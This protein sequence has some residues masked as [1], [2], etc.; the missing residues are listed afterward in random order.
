MSFTEQP[1]SRIIGV[2]HYQPEKVLTNFDLEK[3]VET[4]DE[5]IQ[6]RT[7]IIERRIA[8]DDEEL[9]AMSVA[10]ARMAIEHAGIDV[11]DIDMVVLATLSAEDRSPNIAG[12]VSAALGC[13]APAVMDINVACSGFAHALALADMAIATGSARTA[14][15]IGME[16]LSAFTDWSDRSTCV[17][18]ADGGGAA[19]L[20]TAESGGVSPVTWGSAPELAGAVRV[21]RPS[22]SFSQDGRQILRWSMVEAKR[23]AQRIVERA[24][25]TMEDI[26]VFI[27]HQA[28]LRMI[29]PL[30][31]GLGLREDA[32]VA[33]DVQWS[34]NTSAGTIPLA[35]SKLVH[36]GKAQSG[37]TAL[38][39]GFGGGFAWAGQVVTLP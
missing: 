14:L 20:T 13:T 27:P 24:G 5:W 12:R 25:L 3:M 35:M 33:D 39:F 26:D 4:S 38:L 11:V 32:V 18:V 31:T 17:L 30:A 8:A 10:A 2:G 19:V 1:G 29:E 36:D 15:V 9:D 23:I 21:E 37:A 7:G 34:G 28:N 16:K 6:Q 22:G